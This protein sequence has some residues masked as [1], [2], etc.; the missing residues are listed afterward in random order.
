ME[1]LIYGEYDVY[2]V[3]FIIMY[4]RFII[5]L[6]GD[7]ILTIITIVNIGVMILIVMDLVIMVK[8]L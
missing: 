2:I 5:V 7:I 6:V 4:Q 3:I 8:F 1:M